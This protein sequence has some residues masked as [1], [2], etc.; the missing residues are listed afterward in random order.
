[1]PTVGLEYRYPHQRSALGST[2]IEPIAQIIIRP[3][4]TYAGRL[5]NEDAQSCV[6]HFRTCQRWPSLGL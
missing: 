4:E 2:T 3:N 1:M 5:P 6:R